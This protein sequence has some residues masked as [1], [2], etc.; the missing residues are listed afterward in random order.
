[1]AK[2]VDTGPPAK[3]RVILLL[4]GESGSGKSFFVANLKNA[5]IFD[6]DIGGG[7][8]YAEERIRRNGSE[9]I[10][11]GSYLDIIEEIGKRQKHLDNI[12]TLAIDHLS[13]LQQ[14]ANLR[15]NPSMASDYGKANEK[16]TK[17]WRKI[18]ELTRNRDFN[19][20]CTAHQKAKFEN[21]K[22]VGITT[23]A[24]KNIEGDM[25]IVLYLLKAEGKKPTAQN[26][27]IARVAK[28]RR[29]PDDSRGLIPDVFP[30]TMDK[31]LEMHGSDMS[32]QRHEIPM[33]TPEQ[34]AELERLVNIVK[35]PEDT[36]AKWLSKAKAESFSDMTAEVIAK[37]IAYTTSLV[38]AP[39][40]KGAA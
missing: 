2:K 9:R 26:P 7:L 27:P 16:A 31:F 8:S 21:D 18:R 28:W 19:L 30:L 39:E 34:A 5:L 1:M 14:E 37:C 22:V 10:E 20:V 35:L 6:T 17:E 15:H 13:T 11:V 32:G 3:E 29:D 33:A 4:A 38:A 36:V 40:A 25:S 12:T 24:S 23:D